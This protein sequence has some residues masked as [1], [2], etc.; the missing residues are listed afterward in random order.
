MQKELRMLL[1]VAF[2]AFPSAP[3]TAMSAKGNR[4]ASSTWF[5]MLER[6]I[7]ARRIGNYALRVSL[8]GTEHRLVGGQ[9]RRRCQT[10]KKKMA[11]AR[12]IRISA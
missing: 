4:S 9:Q 8:P 7:M 3:A 5:S 10:E 1:F 12:V 11:P 2:L 6:V